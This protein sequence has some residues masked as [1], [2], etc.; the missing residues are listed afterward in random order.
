MCYILFFLIYNIEYIFSIKLGDMIGE[1]EMLI[2]I[3][4]IVNDNVNLV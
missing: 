1:Y 2:C 3:E 4:I